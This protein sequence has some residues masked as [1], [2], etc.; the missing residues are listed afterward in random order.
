M[1]E[2]LSLLI[3]AY[4]IIEAELFVQRDGLYQGKRRQTMYIITKLIID[5]ILKESG[6]D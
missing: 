3:K 2:Y 4:Q 6:G 5:E 1:S